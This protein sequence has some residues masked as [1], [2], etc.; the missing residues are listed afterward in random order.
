MSKFI[1][2]NLKS[3]RALNVFIIKRKLENK[4]FNL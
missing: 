3:W 4:A 2:C 1:E